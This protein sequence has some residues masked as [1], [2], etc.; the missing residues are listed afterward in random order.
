MV[1]E[2]SDKVF[3][4]VGDLLRWCDIYF[5]GISL[6]VVV[7]VFCWIDVYLFLIGFG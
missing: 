6:V 7:F 5:D 4:Y 3:M 2:G 1:L